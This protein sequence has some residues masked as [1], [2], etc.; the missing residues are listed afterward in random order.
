MY[1]VTLIYIEFI[2]QV[3]LVYLT[4]AHERHQRCPKRE[5]W[6]VVSSGYWIISKTYMML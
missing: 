6:S 3:L 1:T 4:S 5:R 2:V